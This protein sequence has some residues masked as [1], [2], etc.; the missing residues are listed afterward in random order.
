MECFVMIT[1]KMKEV[2]EEIEELVWKHDISY[3]DAIVIYCEDKNVD[4]ETFAK[5][6]KNNEMIKAK[7]QFEAEALN[8]LPKSNTLPV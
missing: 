6:L 3:M 8:Y 5:A 4:I 2:L 7:L 1:S